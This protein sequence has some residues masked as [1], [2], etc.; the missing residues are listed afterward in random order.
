MSACAVGAKYGQKTR[1]DQESPTATS[2]ESGAKA[3][4]CT[5][6]L[7]STPP[8]GRADHLR[9]PSSPPRTHPT[10]TLYK[11]QAHRPLRE[12]VREAVTCS[13]CP[14]AGGAPE[15]LACISCLASSWCSSTGNG[16]GP[17]PVLEPAHRCYIVPHGEP[18]MKPS[19][20]STFPVLFFFFK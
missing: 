4:Y 20:F 1:K 2:E 5:C 11:V 7:H 3:G 13:C 12:R 10:H 15:N 9:H 14:R 19:C 16:Q 17:W 6:P 8:K 18:G